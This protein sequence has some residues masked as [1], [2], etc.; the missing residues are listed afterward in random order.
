MAKGH[1]SFNEEIFV[2]FSSRSGSLE[3]APG[4]SVSSPSCG[5]L[6]Q[7]E[8]VMEAFSDPSFLKQVRRLEAMLRVRERA[9]ARDGAHSDAGRAVHRCVVRDIWCCL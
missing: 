4:T 6:S 1:S 9:V 2:N 7:S 8:L 3:H 5:S